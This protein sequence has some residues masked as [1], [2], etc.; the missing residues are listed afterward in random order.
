[1][2]RTPCDVR[3]ADD[4]EVDAYEVNYPDGNTFFE[5]KD[6]HTMVLDGAGYWCF[7]NLAPTNELVATSIRAPIR[8]GATTNFDPATVDHIPKRLHERLLGDD[9]PE[10]AE[11][12][13]ECAWYQRHLEAVST[14]V[15]P[16]PRQLY[17]P[18]S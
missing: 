18:C 7:A 12:Q 5:D 10:W 6:G 16:P 11:L 2:E 3:N 1:M 14:P 17:H 9:G 4:T 8:S 15:V 13:H